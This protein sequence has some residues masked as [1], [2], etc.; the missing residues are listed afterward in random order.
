MH[1]LLDAPVLPGFNASA[2]ARALESQSDAQIVAAAMQ[3][4]RR[5][6]GKNIPNP[7]DY[8]ITRWATDPFTFGA[9]SFGSCSKIVQ[10]D[11][12]R[13][14]GGRDSLQVD[15][16]IAYSHI[17]S[18]VLLVHTAERAQES[19]EEFCRCMQGEALHSFSAPT[20]ACAQPCR[21]SFHS[22]CPEMPSEKTP[23]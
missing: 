20:C 18:K 6:Y 15:P 2:Y 9:Y 8:R 11:Q 21:R 3:T 17:L 5:M 13:D 7:S 1:V 12:L 16:E 22:R 4:L 19:K 14:K 23:L 10:L